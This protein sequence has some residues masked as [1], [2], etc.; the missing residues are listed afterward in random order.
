MAHVYSITVAGALWYIGK[1][2]GNR[3]EKHLRRARRFNK[4]LPMHRITPWQIE[5]AS[6]L[7]AGLPVEIHIIADGLTCA[8]AFELEIQLIATMTPIKNKL[9][10]GNGCYGTEQCPA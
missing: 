10:G 9:A 5:L 8:A 4:G 7:A 2:T 1:G 3:A 6:A